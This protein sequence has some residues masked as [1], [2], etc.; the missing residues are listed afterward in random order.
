MIKGSVIALFILLSANS[1][2]SQAETE[3]KLSKPGFK[4]LQLDFTTLLFVNTFGA[5][6]G[7]PKK[8]D[9]TVTILQKTDYI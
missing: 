5:S 8:E 4:S 6:I 9:F 3:L 1:L 7:N 2:F